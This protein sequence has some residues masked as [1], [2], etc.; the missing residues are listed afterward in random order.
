MRG[1]HL[2]SKQN[3]FESRNRPF[4]TAR[5]DFTRSNTRPAGGPVRERNPQGVGVRA[6]PTVG[7]V[8]EAR[9]HGGGPT[10]SPGRFFASLV[11]LAALVLGI[12][13]LPGVIGQRATDSLSPTG[14]SDVRGIAVVLKDKDHPGQG[15][16]H[17][18]GRK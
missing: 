11:T 14:S 7:R 5:P 12:L 8:V 15:A 1:R 2:A 9:L 10:M 3:P 18:Q 16:E 6:D 17:G 13:V 4:S